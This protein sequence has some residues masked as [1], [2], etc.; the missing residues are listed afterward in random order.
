MKI[1]E[2]LLPKSLVDRD[3][4]PTITKEIDILQQRMDQYV[5]KIQD[6][7]TSSAG[8][9]FLRDKLRSDYDSLKTALKLR[10]TSEESPAKEWEVYDTKTN[11][12]VGGPY[13]SVSRARL[14]RDKK[15]IKHGAIRYQVREIGGNS[16]MEA[17]TKLPLTNADFDLVKTV[18]QRPIPAVIASIY[19]S[20][21]IEDDELNDMI[22]SLE[23]TEPDRDIRP[24][25]V[26][27]FRRVMPDQMHRFGQ[28]V[29][30]EQQ[31]QG[32]L[33]VVHG[34]DPKMYKGGTD[35]GTES[36]GNAYGRR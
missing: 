8:K 17:V 1:L 9:E 29:A 35:T 24:L 13:S 16:I 34:Y 32:V 14:A 7:A 11:K 18:M 31:R 10:E 26:D 5:D 27:W 30:G 3:L 6:P 36:S 23:D 15:D 2:L 25:I 19:I 12:V 22:A 4:S 28:E 20:D 21:I 33:S